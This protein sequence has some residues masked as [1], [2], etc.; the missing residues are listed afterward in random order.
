MK[1]AIDSVVKQTN[2]NW[3]LCIL[4]DDY[5]GTVIENYVS[6]LS[7][8]RIKY[9]RNAT[10]L[11]ANANYRKALE[12][13]E[14]PYFMMFGAD[15]IL[16]TNYVGTIL[17]QIEANPEI[18]IFQ[19]GVR[20]IDGEGQLAKSLVD[21]V[22]DYIRPKDGVH[23]GS[24]LASRL[25]VGNFTYFPSITWKTDIVRAIGF[26]KNFHVT[27]D[28]ALICDIL[29]ADCKML[30]SSDPIFQYRRHASSDSSLKTLT[31]DRFSEE[32]RLCASF[33]N[34]FRT[35]KWFLASLSAAF[36]PTIR[37]HMFLLLPKV[38]TKP[39]IFFRI[40]KGALL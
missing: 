39:V 5:P 14:T 10:N 15:D 11:G 32:I 3:R 9:I 21:S 27:Q 26:R 38:A 33:R 34:S 25:M 7:D 20:V 22:K 36:R 23:S 35:K 24:R 6:S 1:L 12:F 37:L 17:G 29:L 28:L 16:E 19:P 31:G 18:A 8:S 40:L 30:V 4:D 13:I 2:E